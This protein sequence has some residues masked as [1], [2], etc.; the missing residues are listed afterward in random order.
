M[1]RFHVLALLGAALSAG[2]AAQNAPKPISRTDYLNVVNGHFN[3]ADANHDGFL[4]KAEVTAQEQKDL[5]A[6]KARIAQQMQ[7]Q[8]NKLDTNHDGKL[9]LQEFYAAG[10]S[11]KANETPDQM[12]A[13]L[14]AN[15][16]AKI[17]AAEFRDPEAAKFNRIDANHDGVVTPQEQQAAI[18][19]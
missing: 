1:T 9:S 12:I 7:A 5:D 2:A 14:D 15:H 18:K 10:P 8:F 6:A 16:D 4:T 13:R 11:I 3:G 19:R 17:S